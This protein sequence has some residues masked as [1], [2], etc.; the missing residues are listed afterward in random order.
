LNISKRIEQ[1]DAALGGVRETENARKIRSYLRTKSEDEL[2]AVLRHGPEVGEGPI[3][4][5]LRSLLPAQ[6]QAL[7]IGRRKGEGDL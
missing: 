5:A 7:Q 2:R 3:P 1:L 4:M 6:L